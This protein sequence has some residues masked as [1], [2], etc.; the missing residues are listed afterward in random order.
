[1]ANYDI[2]IS[3]SRQDKETVDMICKRLDDNNISYFRDIFDITISSTFTET[4]A[5]A[6]L[7]CKL[8][9]FIASKHS[10]A[11]SYTSKEVTFAYQ[12]HIAIMPL[13]VDNT[14]MPTHF[15][16]MFSDVQCMRLAESSTTRLISEI[17]DILAGQSVKRQVPTS[18]EVSVV[19]QLKARKK[20]GF[21]GTAFMFL[22]IFFTAMIILGTFLPDDQ[23]DTK[24]EM[25]SNDGGY[26]HITSSRLLTEED[27]KGFSKSDLKIM[28]NEIFARHGYIFRDPMLQE[29]FSQMPWYTPQQA[30][31]SQIALSSVEENNV[32]FI[33][34]YEQ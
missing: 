18:V 9:L 27:I 19:H 24:T 11:S 32:L 12:N 1:M 33:K 31:I 6:I 2:F 15:Q 8:V 25:V 14:P 3:Y 16:F 30:D 10:F 21:L 23:P 5:D 13:L 28:R 20:R 4:L 7:S 22:G 17:K 26:Y 34:R 29:Y